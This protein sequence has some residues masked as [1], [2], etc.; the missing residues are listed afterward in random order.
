[1]RAWGEG[2]GDAFGQTFRPTERG[3][4]GAPS[5]TAYDGFSST[6][7]PVRYHVPVRPP[8]KVPINSVQ[9]RIR[10]RSPGRARCFYADGQ[11][12]LSQQLECNISCKAQGKTEQ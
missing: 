3:L 6:A 1:M 4:P 9:G 7:R 12:F 8:S 11:M 5:G 10:A 2:G